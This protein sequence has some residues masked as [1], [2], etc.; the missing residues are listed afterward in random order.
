VS[1]TLCWSVKGGSGTSVI[2]AGVSLLAATRPAGALLVDLGGDQ[3]AVL[4][5]REVPNP[6]VW[7]WLLDGDSAP[8]DALGRLEVDVAP[9]LRLLPAG[10]S[11]L[12][13]HTPGP[14]AGGP[15]AGG[16]VRRATLLASVLAADRRMV[17]VDAGASSTRRDPVTDA[18]LG[19]LRAQPHRCVLVVR[20][21]YLALRRVHA[22]PVP[23][24][25]VVVVAE[26]WRTLGHEDIA[27][28][29]EAPVVAE[30]PV[31]AAIGRAVD[32]GVLGARPPRVL[33]RALAPLLS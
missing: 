16:L 25:A 7:D 8:P 27:S 18:V 14:L 29:V 4:G 24:D 26:A 13:R 30:V 10:T 19:A 11:V 5:C 31:E 33:L 12:H 17:V 1:V 28:V 32:A 3:P 20:P 21:C 9:G 23:A 22:I 2:S 6:G 15:V